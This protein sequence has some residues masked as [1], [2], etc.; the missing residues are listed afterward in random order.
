M[1]C[2]LEK[3]VVLFV[4]TPY[5]N[6]SMLG[7]LNYQDVRLVSDQVLENRDEN[8]KDFEALTLKVY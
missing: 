3:V 6:F 5:V 8:V 1:F 4:F 7:P 2:L